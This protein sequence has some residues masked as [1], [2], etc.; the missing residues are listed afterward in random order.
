MGFNQV[1]V[2]LYFEEN[3]TEKNPKSMDS[4]QAIHQPIS[5]NP[6]ISGRVAFHSHMTGRARMRLR[7]NAAK[8]MVTILPITS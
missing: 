2:K 6:N 8:R 4:F 3:L 7:K 5:L 1:E